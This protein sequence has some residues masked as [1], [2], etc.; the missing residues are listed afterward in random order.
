MCLLCP[1]CHMIL[2]QHVLFADCARLCY[3]HTLYSFYTL[4]TRTLILF[5]HLGI[6]THSRADSA[7]QH[8]REPFTRACKGLHTSYLVQRCISS[9]H[10]TGDL[11]P[12]TLK[13]FPGPKLQ[14]PPQ[15]TLAPASL[16]SKSSQSFGKAWRLQRRSSE[17]RLSGNSLSFC[18]CPHT[19][20]QGLM[21]AYQHAPLPANLQYHVGFGKCSQLRTKNLNVGRVST[22]CP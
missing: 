10:A 21:H 13:P 20:V 9:R 12:I 18:M 8:K 1:R 4:Y 6:E 16:E 22:A 14:L 19:A 3:L 15:T 17:G 7:R 2:R 11:D 5:L